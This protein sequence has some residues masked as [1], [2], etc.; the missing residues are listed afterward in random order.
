MVRY[1]ILDAEIVQ[2]VLYIGGPTLSMTQHIEEG[3][4]S[5]RY[6]I[7]DI[8]DI[9]EDVFLRSDSAADRALAVL[10]RMRNE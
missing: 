5:Y 4:V 6:D 10:S 8:R 1:C 3:N 9:D 2:H 7:T